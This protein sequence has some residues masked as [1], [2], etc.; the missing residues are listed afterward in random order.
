MSEP[1]EAVVKKDFDKR[2]EQLWKLELLRD[3]LAE[4]LSM[5]ASD[6]IENPVRFAKQVLVAHGLYSPSTHNPE[7]EE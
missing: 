5:I 6:E 1:F 7:K 3:D 2:R 4:A